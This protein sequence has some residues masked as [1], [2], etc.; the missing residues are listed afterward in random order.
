MVIVP[1]GEHLGRVDRRRT[2]SL[3]GSGTAIMDEKI[4]GAALKELCGVRADHLHI[5]VISQDVPGRLG[6]ISV[7]LV[8]DEPHRRIRRGDHPREARPGTGTRLTDDGSAGKPGSEHREQSPDLRPDTETESELLGSL[9][10][11]S[12]KL[13]GRGS[14]AGAAIRGCPAKRHGGIL[15]D[16]GAPFRR[17][18]AAICALDLNA[19]M[20]RLTRPH[21]RSGATAIASGSP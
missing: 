21:G 13:W 16:P 12:H 4:E 1:P 20:R 6:T 5:P 7:A 3:A 9:N 15:V 14:P 10:R 18:G 2:R 19:H 17:P 8:A 11:G